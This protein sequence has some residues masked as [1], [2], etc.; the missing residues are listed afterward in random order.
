[1]IIRDPLYNYISIDTKKDRW[2]LELL[3][4]PELQRL[5]R[6]HQLGVSYLPEK[7]SD[8]QSMKNAIRVTV[9]GE[10]RPIEVSRLL[11]RLKPLTQEPVD[12]YRYYVP[13]EVRTAVQRLRDK[14]NT[15]VEAQTET[16]VMDYCIQMAMTTELPDSHLQLLTGRIAGGRTGVYRLAIRPEAGC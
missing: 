14:W 10:P 3:D 12:R 15:Q 2:L 16:F 13:T 8:E 9:E 5:R 7:E 1:M 11:P 4:C 6:V